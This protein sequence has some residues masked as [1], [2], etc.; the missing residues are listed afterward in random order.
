MRLKIVAVSLPLAAFVAVA[1][2]NKDVEA[3]PTA[4]AEATLPAGAANAAVPAAAPAKRKSNKQY[5]VTVRPVTIKVGGK[6][7]A[8]IIIE[9]TGGMKFNKDFPS[10]FIVTAGKHAACDKKKLSARKGDVKIDG[11]K[12]LVNVPLSARATGTGALSVIGNFSV[13]SDEQCYVLRGERL[14][15][16][17]TV[18]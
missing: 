11:K 3:S 13:C 2:N 10:S 17:V 8:K 4:V 15:L 14:S 18:R 16:P 5:K 6:A 1:C 9:P 12:G 7:V